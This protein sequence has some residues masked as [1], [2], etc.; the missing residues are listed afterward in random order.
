[1]MKLNRKNAWN[2]KVA[3]AVALGIVAMV[4]LAPR[5]T[6]ADQ[7][8]PMMTVGYQSGMITG[9]YETTFQIDHRTY[10]LTPDAVL[11]D[12]HGDE[13][14]VGY[15]RMDIEVKFH[16]QKDSKDKIDRMILFL[17]E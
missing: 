10:S 14:N 15:L 17:P 4:G 12:R 6:C 11:L 13:L 3:Y 16:L 5:T 1:M 7:Q 8:P 2:R 9:V